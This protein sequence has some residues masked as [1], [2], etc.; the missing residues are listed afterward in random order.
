MLNNVIMIV[1]LPFTRFLRQ[2][3]RT[4]NN[5][6]LRMH[7]VNGRMLQTRHYISS[8]IDKKDVPIGLLF[9]KAKGSLG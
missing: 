8:Y 7:D 4:L 3:G 2:F 9:H 6:P 1:T 5:S